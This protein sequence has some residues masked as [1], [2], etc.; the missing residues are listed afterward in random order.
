MGTTQ[1]ALRVSDEDFEGISDSLM[2]PP[3]SLQMNLRISLT[4]HNDR[5][6]I[7]LLKEERMIL[8]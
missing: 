2:Q 7:E 3:D 8:F 6:N 4:V 1:E 5:Q